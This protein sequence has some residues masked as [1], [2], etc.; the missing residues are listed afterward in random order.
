MKTQLQIMALIAALAMSHAVV[1]AQDEQQ[2]TVAATNQTTTQAD[3][4]GD[5]SNQSSVRYAC[6]M[7]KLERRVE[8]DYPDA[9]A[10]LPCEVNYYKDV[11][12]PGQQFRLWI[13]D[14]N[15]GYCR[16]QA[17]GLIRKLTEL[18]W[19]CTRQ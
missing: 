18:G 9:P 19:D 13:A 10:P 14:N 5:Q 1:I 4:S 15:Q 8:V 12:A 17:E 3:E 16:F 7:A 6:K 2:D 11:E